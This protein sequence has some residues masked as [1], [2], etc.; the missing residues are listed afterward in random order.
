M[1]D[2]DRFWGL[3]MVDF[4]SLHENGAEEEVLRKGLKS[5]T[6]LDLD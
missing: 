4:G 2:F 5:T 3:K 6:I 1:A